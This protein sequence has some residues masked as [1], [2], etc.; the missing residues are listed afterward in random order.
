[1]EA[2]NE[3]IA[4]SSLSTHHIHKLFHSLELTQDEPRDEPENFFHVHAIDGNWLRKANSP[5]YL[6]DVFSDMRISEVILLLATLLTFFIS[7][8]L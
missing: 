2:N 4:L 1:M 8:L 3:F 5:Q 6:K 7:Q